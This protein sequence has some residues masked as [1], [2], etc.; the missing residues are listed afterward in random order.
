MANLEQAARGAL[1][2]LVR[3]A[4]D[5]ISRCGSVATEPG[6]V[7]GALHLGQPNRGRHELVAPLPFLDEGLVAL[8]SGDRRSER[9]VDLFAAGMLSL[10]VVRAGDGGVK[11]LPERAE[12]L[13]SDE[14]FV[15]NSS[16]RM[17][18]LHVVSLNVTNFGC[19]VRGICRL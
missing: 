16:E 13:N 10:R 15:G 8:A 3:R 7:V 14:L 11:V 4:S 18:I 6:L 1:E 5:V 2:R 19:M 12:R 17:L 9:G